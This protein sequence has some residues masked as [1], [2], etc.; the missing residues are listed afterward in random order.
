MKSPSSQSADP[1][2]PPEP[3]TM[4]VTVRD[5]NAESPWGSGLTNPITRKVEISAFCQQ[6]G[7]GAR[8]GEPR[9]EQRCDDGA[10]YSVQKWDNPCGHVDHYTHVLAEASAR[11]AAQALTPAARSTGPAVLLAEARWAL[12]GTSDGTEIHD[13]AEVPAGEIRRILAELAEQPPSW[14]V[15]VAALNLATDAGLSVMVDDGTSVD[16]PVRWDGT[17]R[18]GIV[19]PDTPDPAEGGGRR[20]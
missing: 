4:T 12:L 17:V 11:A 20:G 7:C 3:Q 16:H 1:Q 14:A 13:D 6:P 5:R 18:R 8:R 15:V 10:F 2:A 19:D 9:Y